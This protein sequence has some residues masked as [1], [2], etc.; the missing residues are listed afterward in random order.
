LTVAELLALLAALGTDSTTIIDLLKPYS[1][2]QEITS[3]LNLSELLIP[4][5]ASLASK[6]VA[7]YSGA[8]GTPITVAS[9]TALL[10]NQYPLPPA[11]Q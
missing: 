4:L 1:P 8:S 5:L 10:P 11:D 2:D 6:G 3:I 9:I 7:A